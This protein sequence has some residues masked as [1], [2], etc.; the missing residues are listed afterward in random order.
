MSQKP[1]LSR[2]NF[3]TGAAATTVAGTAALIAAPK[4][5]PPQPVKTSKAQIEPGLGYQLTDHIRNYY[6][7]TSV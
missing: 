6:R 5:Q 4:A 2:R 1:K 3:L 7:T